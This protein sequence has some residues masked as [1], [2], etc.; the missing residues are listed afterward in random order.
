MTNIMK[1]KYISKSR[2]T[3]DFNLNKVKVSYKQNDNS[4]RLWAVG[5][6]SLQN[7][8]REIRHTIA[9]DLY[10]DVDIVNCHPTLIY[11]YAEKNDLKCKYIEKNI[12]NRE[13]ILNELSILYDNSKEDIKNAFLKLINGGKNFLNL[14]LDDIPEFVQ[15]FELEIIQIQKYIFENEKKYKELGIKSSKKIVKMN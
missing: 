9:N 10:I 5:A 6:L 11:Q 1:K 15:K 14:K 13:H 12:K 3:K 8:T 2:L 4:G 7:V